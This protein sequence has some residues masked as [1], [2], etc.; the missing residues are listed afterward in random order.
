MSDGTAAGVASRGRVAAWQSEG[1]D[2]SLERPH[3]RH[4]LGRCPTPRPLGMSCRGDARGR[5]HVWFP[6]PCLAV[7]YDSGRG[8]RGHRRSARLGWATATDW[9]AVLLGAT[10]VTDEASSWSGEWGHRLGRRSRPGRRPTKCCL[11][12]TVGPGI[13]AG[14][15]RRMCCR[16]TKAAA[17]SPTLP[18]LMNSS[19]G[20][21]AIERGPSS[22]R[23]YAEI[24]SRLFSIPDRRLRV[25]KSAEFP[26][27]YIDFA[28]RSRSNDFFL[29]TGSHWRAFEPAISARGSPVMEG[30]RE[31]EGR[32][33]VAR[34]DI[35]RQS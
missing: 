11:V 13:C 5:R 27:D 12:G 34:V 33:F 10:G 8:D 15:A 22:G 17:G 30:A 29:R 19:R 1:A 25:W 21:I 2:F 32:Q 14:A 16:W 20:A 7:G 4:G 31:R 26:V 28:R 3:R 18:P 24:R 23:D 6:G 9:A 35:R